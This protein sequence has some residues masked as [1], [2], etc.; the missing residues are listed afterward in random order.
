MNIIYGLF[1]QF[2]LLLFSITVHEFAH[3]YVA[4]KRGDSTAR[5]LGRL[6]LNP[7]AHVDFFGTIILPV[8]AIVT[9][10]PVFGWAKP[11]PVN[12]YELFNPKKD[13]AYVGLAG[14]VAN[15]LLAILSGLALRIINSLQGLNFVSPIFIFLIYIN[16]LLP[17]FNLIPVPP[18]DGSR[19]VAGLLPSELSYQ[20]EKLTPYGF[21]IVIFLLMSGFLNIIFRVIVEPIV[22]LILKYIAGSGI[23]V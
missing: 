6:T 16:V 15:L 2:P 23:Y 9:G 21:I 4:D 18:L 14:P 3:G 8:I 17:V 11:V 1:V 19:V 7:L 5:I 22:S 20:Y 12:P 10:A 13:M